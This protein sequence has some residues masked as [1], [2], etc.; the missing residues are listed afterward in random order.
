MVPSGAP[1]PQRAAGRIKTPAGQKFSLWKPAFFTCKRIKLI[2]ILWMRRSCSEARKGKKIM[3]AISN[4]GVKSMTRRC[5]CK[6]ND[7]W[8][9]VFTYKLKLP[10]HCAIVKNKSISIP[11]NG[12]G[13]VKCSLPPT[14][15]GFELEPG[16]LAARFCSS[17]SLW[18][19]RASLCAAAWFLTWSKLLT[20]WSHGGHTSR[21]VTNESQCSSALPIQD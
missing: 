2:H 10:R 15:P 12:A 20:K 3:M 11:L 9:T 4:G 5:F 17:A 8:S 7:P 16:W 6:E 13:S 21:T 14:N 1:E 19:Q 18:H